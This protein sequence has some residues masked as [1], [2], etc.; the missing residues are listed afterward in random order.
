MK[1]ALVFLLLLGLGFALL[2]LAVGDEPIAGRTS[3]ANQAP[4]SGSPVAPVAPV[5][6]E[7]QQPPDA[8]RGEGGVTVTAGKMNATVTHTGRLDMPR[9]RT[10][11]EGGGRFRREEVFR[12]K[13]RD[14]QPFGAGQQQL[15]D[16]EVQVFDRGA[17]VAILTATRAFVQLGRDATGQLSLDETKVI[18]LR[19][20]VLAAAPSSKLAGLRIEL[21]NATVRVEADQ[22]LLDTP[23]DQVVTITN[24]GEHP[25]TL[26]G[27]G[28]HAR[29]PRDSRSG[30]QQ[31]DIELLRQ[32]QL[33]LEGVTV[34]AQGRLRY[35]EDLATGA[36]QLHLIDAVVASGQLGKLQLPGAATEPADATKAAA[37]GEPS[38]LRGD[39]FLAWLRRE[40][41]QVGGRATGGDRG[42]D[43]RLL[44]QR[45]ELRGASTVAELPEGRLTS[46]QLTTVPGLLGEPWLLT[47]DGG[48]VQ[49]EQTRPRPGHHGPLASATASRRL[50]LVRPEHHVGADLRAFGMPLWTLQPLATLQVVLGE[51]EISVQQGRRS[52][53]TAD[54]LHAFHRQSAER[55]VLQGLGPVQV[56][57]A[58][59]A[60]GKPGVR[61]HGNDGF[62][63]RSGPAQDELRLGPET[64]TAGD[65]AATARWQAH[66]YE[67]QRGDARLE[68]FGSCDLVQRDD[69]TTVH[70]LVPEARFAASMQRPGLQLEHV[71]ELT[72]RWAADQ[73][74]DLDVAGWPLAIEFTDGK[75]VTR[76]RSPRLQQIG[77]G[78]LRLRPVP[79]DAPPDRW[80]ALAA[81]D[82]LPW[83][84]RTMPA[85]R[86]EAMQ[87]IDLRGPQIDVHH[88]GGRSVVIEAIAVGDE[89]PQITAALQQD[90]QDHLSQLQCRA[91]RLRLLPFAVP[92]ALQQ[93]FTRGA[94]PLQI[95]HAGPTAAPWLVVDVV[96]EFCIDDPQEG[97]VEGQ[98]RRLLVSQGGQAAL[99]VGDPDR[100]QPARVRRRHQGRDLVL[101]GASVR[102][103]RDAGE[104]QL[105]ASGTFP[106][107]STF[108][109][110]IVTL[111]EA[112]QS[113]LLSHMQA[114][115]RGNIE[116]RPNEVLFLG[117]VVA[118]GLDQDGIVAE[119]GM[120][121]E[122]RQ[123]R[124]VRQASTGDVV[125]LVATDV[126]LAWPQL[127]ARCRDLELDVR[128]HRLVASDPNGVRVTPP[129]G[130][131]FTTPWLEFDYETLALRTWQ[132]R[133]TP[134]PAALREGDA[135]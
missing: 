100:L 37:D 1:R 97:R 6:P 91:E 90:G 43:S 112:G 133:G 106:D 13:A 69:E 129:R 126:Q 123:L 128:R 38:S 73:V 115:C 10:I 94:L 68:G 110:P 47:A 19:G 127:S 75:E 125:Q 89:M 25:A 114:L 132:G 9:W 116:V 85:P 2:Q 62:W 36:A 59:K 64:A 118:D 104:L 57:Y 72:A 82:R 46:K 77:P 135:K 42:A 119:D 107:R 52:L 34:R 86:G 24:Q 30:V 58:G 121:V 39:E 120:H 14:S 3:G 78:S 56:D 83:L 41:R 22:I 8:E 92:P 109:P 54:G 95:A 18:D 51:G 124:L 15:D 32:P 134:Q 87:A 61:A 98:A 79:D 53:R 111:H 35:R 26:R 63:L 55:T 11:D 96:A 50:H 16:V 33:E 130:L 49:L 29:V 28:A 67:V 4:A 76:A 70:L 122:A 5:A 12:L 21:G 48:P 20:T 23:A 81:A 105:V 102:V 71:R 93:W 40:P 44:W 74:H 84:Q 31:L 65:A 131:E 103:F 60:P 113:S 101:D 66:R 88:A 45:A 27:L 17:V 80:S 7:P 117:P 108:V 99:F